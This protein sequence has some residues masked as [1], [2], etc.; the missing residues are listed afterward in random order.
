MKINFNNVLINND[1][2][3]KYEDMV[4]DIHNKLH[5]NCNSQDNFMGWL[6]L[7]I[8]YDKEELEQIIDETIN[9]LKPDG[10]KGMGM[11]IKAVSAKCGAA[12][13]MKKVS[14]IVKEKLS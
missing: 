4:K 3:N 1:E 11:V 13:D 6:D 14:S 7:P 12:A 9:E 10:L 2:I 8:N 5:D